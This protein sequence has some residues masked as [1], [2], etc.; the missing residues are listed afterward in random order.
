M[1]P[2]ALAIWDVHKCLGANLALMGVDLAVQAGEVVVLLGPNG[3][4]KTTLLRC[5]TGRL[6]PDRGRVAL[7]GQDPTRRVARQRL[8]L[9]PQDLALFPKLSVQENLEIFGRLLQVPRRSLAERVRRGLE[10]AALTDR[11]HH[12]VDTLSGGMRRRLNLVASLLHEPDV[13]LLDEPTAGV[14]VHALERIEA[15]LSAERAQGAAVLL[16]T[17]DLDLT[18]RLADRVVVM[19]AG[20]IRAE[21]VPAALIEQEF[22]GRLDVS[23]T[24]SRRPDPV[25]ADLLAGWGFVE[26]GPLTYARPCLSEQ[27][28]VLLRDLEARGIRARELRVRDPGLV[29][30]YEAVLRGE[31]LR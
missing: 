16:I 14:D 17:H 3:A 4:G 30:L 12:P 8:G 21:G 20:R 7:H 26:R 6:R 28:D 29:D 19:S 2:P 10:R 22:G 23:L 13:L 5:A 9:V 25:F 15:V 1:N 27:V 31:S 24:L 18:E 11:A